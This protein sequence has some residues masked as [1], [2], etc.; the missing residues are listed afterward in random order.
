MNSHFPD[1][2]LLEKLT[3]VPGVP[4][5]E[6]PVA[7]IIRSSLPSKIRECS[8]DRLGNLVVHIPGKGK[9]VM[10]AAHMDEVG[11]IVQR[12]LPSGFLK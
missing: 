3:A 5:R 6:E 1:F 9:R 7:E 12:I 2:E 8:V 11:L 4:G 10:L